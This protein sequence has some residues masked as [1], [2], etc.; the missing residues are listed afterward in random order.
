MQATTQNEDLDLISTGVGPPGLYMYIYMRI[1][2]QQML[3]LLLALKP[4][5]CI[6]ENASRH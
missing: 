1:F 5:Q 4:L 2:Q 3:T 6:D